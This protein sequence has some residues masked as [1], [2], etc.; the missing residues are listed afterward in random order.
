MVLVYSNQFRWLCGGVGGLLL[1][2]YVLFIPDARRTYE[3]CARALIDIQYSIYVR[4]YV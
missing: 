1:T 3:I 2:N 4:G